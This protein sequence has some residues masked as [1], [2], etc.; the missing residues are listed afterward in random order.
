ML[1][2]YGFL[3][4]NAE[5]TA[6]LVLPLKNSLGRKSEVK[7]TVSVQ[8]LA[9]LEMLLITLLEEVFA[10]SGM[11][12]VEA[13]DVLFMNDTIDGQ[14][15]VRLHEGIDYRIV[16]GLIHSESRRQPELPAES[17]IPPFGEDASVRYAE[18]R[19]ILPEFPVVHKVL[20]IISLRRH[21]DESPD[22]P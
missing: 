8:E 12:S 4:G 5:E 18:Y 16:A 6:V 1:L 14:E 2:T 9:S 7:V 20:N 15:L 21:R 11:E 19:K 10:F 22:I 13:V 3:V 17:D